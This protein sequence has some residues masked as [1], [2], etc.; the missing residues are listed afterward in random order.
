M[1]VGWGLRRRFPRAA[2]AL[3]ALTLLPVAVLVASAHVGP[4]VSSPILAR[5]A[6]YAEDALLPSVEALQRSE[7][8]NLFAPFYWNGAVAT[9]PFVSFGYSLSSGT[10]TSYSSVNQGAAQVLIE[11]I[12]VDGLWG[13]ASP[14]LAGPTFSVDGLGV[15]VV[16]HQE[17]MA[18]L[19]IQ[20]ASGPRSA[21]FAFPP[22]TTALAI[23]RAD[24]WPRAV[25]SFSNGDSRGSIILGMGAMTVNG[26]TVTATLESGDYLALRVLPAFVDN[27]DARSAILD[28]FAS[29]RLAAEYDL[30]AMT[31][32]GYLENAAE[33]EPNLSMSS[34]VVGFST[35]A[36]TMNSLEN[37]AGLVLLAFDPRTMPADPSHR[38]VVRADGAEIAETSDPLAALHAA[39]GSASQASFSLL[40]MDATVLVVYLPTLTVSSLQVQ[41]V[42][43]P[44]E[45]PDGPTELAMVAA[46]FLVSM[47]AAA[48]FR[49]R[50][51]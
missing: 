22:S 4:A 15:T 24:S 33:Y 40:S 30:V 42:D 32:G 47:A 43:R 45:G 16:A 31:S 41:S 19:E 23:S 1:R 44:A 27:H 11:S 36:M 37:G 12:Q 10:L 51:P 28:A 26:N 14:Q 3:V 7:A 6:L 18:L 2:T 46:V 35:A 17:P 39:P 38:I 25:L 5:S 9:G 49:P 29:G 20:V 13:G 50:R 48:M 34:D 8:S 21:V